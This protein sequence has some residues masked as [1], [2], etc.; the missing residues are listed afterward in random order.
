MDRKL[1]I[2][3]YICANLSSVDCKDIVERILQL[4][5]KEILKQHKA[6]ISYNE[7]EHHWYTRINGKKIKRKNLDDLEDVIIEHYILNQQHTLISIFPDFLERRKLEVSSRTW[8][9]DIR[10][11][12]IYL[13][14]SDLGNKVISELTLNDGY[15][16]LKLC[17]KRKPDMTKKYWNNVNGF[18]NKMF[19]YSID[20]DYRQNNPFKHLKP[21]KDLFR[22]TQKT[23][24]GDTVFSRSEQVAIITSAEKDSAKTN[25][26]EPLGIVLLFML[27]LRDG[28]LCAIK[29]S[30]IEETINGK[31]IHIQRELVANIN[32]DGKA[33]GFTILEHCKTP[34][35]DRRLLLNSKAI[36]ILKRIKVINNSNNLPTSLND[37]I[38]LRVYNKEITFCTPRSFDPRLRKYCK[39]ANMDIIKSPHDIRRTVLTNLYMAHMPLKKIQE[40]AGHSSLKQTMDYIRITDDDMDMM[41]YLNTLSNESLENV[42]SIRK[43]A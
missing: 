19:Q 18:L 10:Y 21:M 8:M 29:W 38:F 16:F 40:Y 13:K 20:M 28:E 5:R 12:E 11:F 36:E 24:D 17:L 22:K 23:R 4:K 30:D 43:K 37:F 41:Q 34:A 31:Y 15:D 6:K 35:G 2:N 32:N 42:I 33:E 27:G 39:Q 14:D 26:A 1:L 3:N 7:K 9:K 25:K